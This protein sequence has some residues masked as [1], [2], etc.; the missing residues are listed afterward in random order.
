[1]PSPL[2]GEGLLDAATGD[3]G[4]R[5]GLREPLTHLSAWED[6]CALS[7]KG[8]GHKGASRAFWRNE[9]NAGFVEAG[10]AMFDG[11]ARTNLWLWK[12]MRD[13][14]SLFPA[15]YLQGA[16]QPQRVARIRDSK[17][18]QTVAATLRPR[19]VGWDDDVGRANEATCECRKPSPRDSHCFRL[20]LTM[21]KTTRACEASAFADSHRG[22]FRG[23][24]H[25]H[26]GESEPDT[27]ERKIDPLTAKR[28]N[29]LLHRQLHK[30][31]RWATRDEE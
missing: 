14:W 12:K 17:S 19:R 27:D 26:F 11:K 31:Q 20:F 22:D 29:P 7:R 16:V 13:E 6:H 24:N 18:G 30:S 8:R 28:K 15:C 25:A 5:G 9:A 1:M 21:E 23:A 4:V 2:A 10:T 3:D